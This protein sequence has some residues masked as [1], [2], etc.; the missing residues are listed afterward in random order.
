MVHNRLRVTTSLQC[1][2]VAANQIFGVDVS[3][4]R[5]P[6][7]DVVGLWIKFAGL[8]EGIENSQRLGVHATAGAPLPA[9]IVGRQI[10]I[11]FMGHEKG[12]SVTPVTDQVFDEE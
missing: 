12:L 1:G 3:K 10:A 5:Q 11:H 4:L 8:G 7:T 9:A 6:A 2:D